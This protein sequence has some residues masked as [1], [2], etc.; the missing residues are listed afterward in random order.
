MFLS[1]VARPDFLGC[2]SEPS[3]GKLGGV[4]APG[5]KEAGG[6]FIEDA[7]GTGVLD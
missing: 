7:I 5:I 3:F 4:A 2:R 1:E 6:Q